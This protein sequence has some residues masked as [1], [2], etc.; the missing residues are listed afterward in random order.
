[1]K[2]FDGGATIIIVV[3]ALIAG[4]ASVKYLK[5]EDN[6]VEELAEEIIEHKT[7]WELDITPGSKE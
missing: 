5:K 6:V 2:L 7:G 1:M 4:Y 3:V